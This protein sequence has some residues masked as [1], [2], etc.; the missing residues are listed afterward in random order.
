MFSHWTFGRKLAIGSVV[1]IL[2]IALLATTTLYCLW[3]AVSARDLA[4][5]HSQNMTDA[6]T[7]HV[8]GLAVGMEF[9]GYLYSGDKG[10]EDRFNQADAQF[11]QALEAM[12]P[13]LL[14][15][16]SRLLLETVAHAETDFVQ[17]ARNVM[18]MRKSAAPADRVLRA[19][20]EGPTPKRELLE[21]SL[22]RLS[23]EER[24]RLS[25]A[26][27]Q[28]SEISFRARLIVFALS[29]L[30]VTVDLVLLWYLTRSLR[31]QIGAAVKH[32]QASVAQLQS[33]MNQTVS[34]S[35]QQTS[36]VVEISTTMKEMLT[37]TSNIAQSAQRVAE[38]ASTVSDA[39]QKGDVVAGK[40]H[41]AVTGIKRQFDQIIEHMLALGKTSQ[42]IGGILDIVNELAEQ[43]NILAINANIEAA[44]AGES[45]RRFAALAEEIRKL[46]DRVSGST[47]EI[48]GLVDEIR[49]AVDATVMA[50]ESS[51]KVVD[52]GT[53]EV[54]DVAA[55]FSQIAQLAANA[56]DATCEIELSTRQESSAANQVNT[57]LGDVANTARE[58][59]SSASQTQQ[60]SSR[61]M[62][63]ALSLAGLIEAPENA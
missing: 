31:R 48:R 45:G 10:S 22:Q 42:Q 9:R 7:L 28:A 26:Q 52:E 3:T 56:T 57:A 50:T 44:V 43:T 25:D 23:D 4:M 51:R 41:T 21:S 58:F 24:A 46:A 63:L 32:V 55:A 20:E 49:A 53:R 37:T 18:E 36:V 6:E 8:F 59:E 11:S 39:A 16:S 35:K 40:A 19:F 15:D 2:A 60:T 34:G 61:L 47:K 29:L 38:Q 17:A 30:V 13:H 1:S 33:A 5:K 14:A 12:R 27:N 62:D 54:A